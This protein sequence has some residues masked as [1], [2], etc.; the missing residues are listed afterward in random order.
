M[1]SG[2]G[3]AV[4]SL[5]NNFCFNSVSILRVN[6]FLSGAGNE[7]VTVLLQYVALVGESSRVAL[8]PPVVGLVLV[9]IFWVYSVRIVETA[10]KLWV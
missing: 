5:N 10:V 8:Y 1:S 4:C 9:Q 6:G 3:G 7:Y 2:G